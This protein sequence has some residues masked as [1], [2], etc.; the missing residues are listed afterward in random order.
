MHKLF[1]SICKEIEKSTCYGRNIEVLFSCLL[2]I[3][4]LCMNELLWHPGRDVEEGHIT[5]YV[6]DHSSFC[7]FSFKY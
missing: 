3:W 7:S 6:Y 2:F 1:N 4:F 5:V